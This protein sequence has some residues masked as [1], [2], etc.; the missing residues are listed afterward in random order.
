ML[1]QRKGFALDLWGLLCVCI[2]SEW[3][4]SLALRQA[5]CGALLCDSRAYVDA[6]LVLARNLSWLLAY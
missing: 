4:G 2:I 5:I 6:P 3:F 1:Y